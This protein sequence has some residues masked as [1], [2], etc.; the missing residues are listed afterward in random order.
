MRTECKLF[1]LIFVRIIVTMIVES[2]CDF[3][4]YDDSDVCKI[5]VPETFSCNFTIQFY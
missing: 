2:V 4:T 5:Q 3:V 1:I